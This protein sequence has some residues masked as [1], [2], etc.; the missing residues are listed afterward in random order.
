M[1]MTMHKICILLDSSGMG[2]IETHVQQL[3]NGLAMAGQQVTV[4]L[5]QNIEQHPLVHSL[6]QSHPDI[7]LC[8]LNGTISAL[9]A[10]LRRE[11]PS[12]L[13]TH[14]Y[15]AGILGRLLAIP[16]VTSVVSTYHAGELPSGR[17]RAYD[18]LDRYLGFA[19]AARFAVSHEIRQ[20]LP[21]SARVLDN[22]VDTRG[23]HQSQGQQL[24]FVGRLSHEKGPDRLLD[25]AQQFPEQNFDIYGDGPL[26]TTL[27]RQPTA[28]VT[29]HGQSDMR[30]YWPYI[31]V[32]IMPSRYEGL[33]MAALEAMA[34]GIPVIASNV[35]DLGRVIEHGINGWLVDKNDA[36]AFER[37]LQQW[38]Q[39]SQAERQQM[40]QQ[41]ITT[42]R[43]RFST[44]AVIP[45]LL[46]TYWQIAK[47][48]SS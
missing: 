11:S 1:V 46:R 47:P 18:L 37:A 34:R 13:H 45:T 48:Q 4:V 40:Q 6:Q 42:I 5:Y 25:L 21:Y 15:K 19:A 23:L 14:G 44:Q 30:H 31:G 7:H 27:T 33:P 35:G 8:Q 22:F 38:L 24:A 20:R 10:F 3:A 32:L 9:W 26:A 16:L 29:F 41:C 39:L 43:S 28:N 17:V 2:G 36:N 12:I